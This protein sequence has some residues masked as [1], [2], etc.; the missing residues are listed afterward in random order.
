MAGFSAVGTL[1]LSTLSTAAEAA[2]NSRELIRNIVL[3]VAQRRDWTEFC[4]L[5]RNGGIN[6]MD[7]ITA[8]IYG[9]IYSHLVP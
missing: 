5:A 1:G 2:V 4:F 6:R 9:K 8:Y 7:S 3:I